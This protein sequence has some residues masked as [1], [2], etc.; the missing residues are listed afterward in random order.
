MGPP[1]GMAFRT[2]GPGY[3]ANPAIPNVLIDQ[4][5]A[6]AALAG[7]DQRGHP[8]RRAPLPAANAFPDTAKAWKRTKS[9]RHSL[10]GRCWPGVCQGNG[11]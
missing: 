1:E 2:K 3:R 5:M 4:R 6:V 10:P 7:V 11:V 8:S 9:P